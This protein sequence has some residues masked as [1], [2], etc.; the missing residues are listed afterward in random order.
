[1]LDLMIQTVKEASE[2]MMGAHDI[3]SQTEAKGNRNFVTV[4]DHKVQKY[5]Y[6]KMHSIRPDIKFLG[7]EDDTENCDPYSGYCFICDPIDGTA[8]FKRNYKHSAISLALAKDGEIIIGVVINPYQNEVF[9]AESGKG[10]FLNGQPIH[11]SSASLK[12]SFV[13]FGT[14]LYYPE[15]INKT[16]SMLTKIMPDCEDI[17]RTGSAA[18][19]LCY[20]ACGRHDMFFELSLFPWDYAAGAL[21]IEEAGGIIT[22]RN[23]CNPPL[24]TRSEIYAGNK[25]VYK[26]FFDKN[27]F[28]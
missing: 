10:A 9:Y 19:D 13:G 6:D 5:I 25:N 17:R 7:E 18:L 1:M 21:I 27:Y 23:G 28:I 22:D 2:I 12:N 11:V 26:E 8:N 24:H 20:V 14:A 3:D 4:Y 15:L 16:M